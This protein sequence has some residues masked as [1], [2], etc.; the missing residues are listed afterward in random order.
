MNIKDVIPDYVPL[1]ART[2]N[3]IRELRAQKLN[4]IRRSQPESVMYLGKTYLTDKNVFPP[5]E[6]SKALASSMKIPRESRVLDWGTGSGVLGIIAAKKGAERV[7]AIDINPH[8]VTVA[9]QNVRLHEVSS[10]VDVY[11][12]DG[13]EKPVSGLKHD[14]IIGNLPFTD[15]PAND[16]IDRAMYDPDFQTNRD[17]FEQTPK[18][19]WDNGVI[20]AAQA[21][22]G[23]L[24]LFFELAQ[25]TKLSTS[26]IGE[27]RMPNDPRIFYAFEMRPN[28][29]L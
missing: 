13:K 4:T 1:S 20:Y 24:N 12:S 9:N 18:T 15:E 6:D 8:A 7:I 27:H 2:K 26:L 23:S 14:V 22:F 16:V 19:L 21:N 25:D 10:I 5:F 28:P 29:T 3:H 17:F 11:E